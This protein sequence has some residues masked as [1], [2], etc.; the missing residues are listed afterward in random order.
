MSWL[1]PLPVAIPLLGAAVCAFGVHLFPRRLSD[2]IALAAVTA[3]LVFCILIMVASMKHEVVHFFGGWRPRSG[4]VL[5]IAFT[6]DPLGAGMA[7]LVSVLVLMMLIYSLRY[8]ADAGRQYN[9]LVLVFCGAMCGFSLTG[10]IFNMFVWFELMGVAAYAL[11]GFKIAELGPLQGSVNMAVTNTVGAYFILLG[12]ALLYGKTGALNLA[13]IGRTLSGQKPSGLVVVAFTL[14]VVGF[15]VK[16]AIVPFHAWLADAHAVA[17]A[18][19]CVL[20]SGVMVELGLLAVAR[21]YWTV[22]DAPFGAHQH[23][24]RNVLLVLGIVSA[25]LGAVMCFLQSHL[26][27]LL[28]YSTISHSGAMLVGIAVLN[29]KSLAGVATMVVSH[30]LIKGAL[31]LCCGIL[32]AELQ[33]VDELRLYGKGRRL[34]VTGVLFVLGAIGMMGLPYVGTY[35]GHAQIDE[36]A[37]LDHIEWVQPVL[38]IATAIAA[39]SILRAGLRV[40]AGW[41]ARED[42]LLSRQAA[43]DSPPTFEGRGLL[44]AVTAVMLALGLVT[45]LVP[46]IGQRAEYG[47]ERFRDRAAYADRVLHGQP[48]KQ[49]PAR[50][51]F[52]IE[53]T[54][55]ASRLYGLGATVLALVVAA[56]GLWR[57]RLPDALRRGTGKLAG[58]P[59]VALKAAH[60]GVIGEYVMWIT[61]GTA[62]LGGVWAFTLR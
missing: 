18:P 7:V 54:G 37:T 58:P 53:H 51:P 31:F 36:G 11:A 45:S 8:L 12:I 59:I 19:V 55:T 52:A 30:G 44:V 32:L 46:G 61:V 1:L 15:L 23:A 42:D 56:F 49:T 26:K 57:Q 28:A 47:A 10:D 14:L 60:S 33:A 27:R 43:E 39:G 40:F 21:I 17:P 62:L 50:L 38:M 13:Q 24:V 9:V 29:S 22:F 16:A 2:A 5:G 3:S 48:M 34:P 25:L 41:G 20:F 6:A 4:V 35:L